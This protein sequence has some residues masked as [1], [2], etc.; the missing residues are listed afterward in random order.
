[1]NRE[2]T[3]QSA[4]K[5]SRTGKT[6]HEMSKYKR[7][8]K[9]NVQVKHRFACRVDTNTRNKIRKRPANYIAG[10]T[11]H[12]NRGKDS[13]AK[14]REKKFNSN[15]STLNNT[16]Q[17]RVSTGKHS[18]LDTPTRHCTFP[19]PSSILVQYA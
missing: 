11:N 13:F 4:K 3:Y 17:I 2:N 9:T 18:I 6:E 8:D 12:E 14:M 15:S 16:P 5:A 7:N 1:M 10:F 19:L